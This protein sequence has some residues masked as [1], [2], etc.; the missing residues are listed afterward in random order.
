MSTVTIG[1]KYTTTSKKDELFSDFG[2]N[3]Q[4]HP[5]KRD[6]TRTV[7]EAAVKRSIINLLQTNYYERFYQPY[8]GANLKHLLFEPAGEEVLSQMRQHILACIAKFE[9]RARVINL[10]LTSS[11]DELSVHVSLLFTTIN[12]TAPVPLNFILNRV[13]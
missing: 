13:R 12:T 1:D 11:P 7:N 5:S 6:L 2:V 3:M 9:P 4:I 10:S 8:L